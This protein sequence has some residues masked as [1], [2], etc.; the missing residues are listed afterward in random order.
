[1]V[2]IFIG[3]KVSVGKCAMQMELSSRVITKKGKSETMVKYGYP[4]R[5]MCE[6]GSLW[7]QVIVIQYSAPLKQPCCTS[8]HE[9]DSLQY[10][11][12]ITQF[13]C[14]NVS[15]NFTILPKEGFY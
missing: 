10:Q 4:C 5:E 12:D 11:V 15:S 3:F 6:L 14:S 9:P 8:L 7:F 13:S 1:M 2:F